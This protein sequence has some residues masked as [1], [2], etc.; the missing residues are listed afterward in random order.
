MSANAFGG[1]AFLDAKHGW[2]I[3]V[4]EGRTAEG[5]LVFRCGRRV[6]PQPR[7]LY[8]GCA[9]RDRFHEITCKQCI[10]RTNAR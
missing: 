10:R 9:Q 7:A 5:Y 8:V 4:L 3:H 2:R 1:R 6:R